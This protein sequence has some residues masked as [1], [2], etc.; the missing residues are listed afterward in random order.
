MR[1][2]PS[3][4][5]TAWCSTLSAEPTSQEEWTYLDNGTIRIGVNR[6]AGATLGWFSLSQV[7]FNYLNRFDLGRYLQ[8][9]WYGDEDGSDWNGK[10]WRWNPVQGGN[11]QYVPAEVTS[12]ETEEF[13]LSS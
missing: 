2:L 4:L 5:L 1:F 13:R 7:D 11:W 8:Q 6:S 10:P 9:S 3:I 12:F